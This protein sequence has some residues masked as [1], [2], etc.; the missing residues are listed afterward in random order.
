MLPFGFSSAPYVFTSIFKPLQKSWRSQGIPIAIFLDDGLGGGTDFVSAKVNSLVVHSDL[1]KSGFVPNEEKSLWEPVQVI[2]WLGVVLDTIDGTIKATDE[3]IEKL[4][5]GL[6]ELLSCQPPRKVHVKRVASVTGQII[7]LSPC[8]GSVARIMTRFLFSVVNS[9]RSWESEVFLSDDSL[10]EISFW[11]DNVVFLNSKVCW[12]VQSLPVKVTFSDASN[13]ACGAF[14]KNSNLVFHQ[15]WSPVE[16]AQSSTWRELKAV[17]LALEAFASHF[18]GVKV[19]WY[20][21][22]QNVESIL[23]NG[24]R[25]ADLHQLALLAF[26][27]CLKFH[28]SL[29][30]KWIPRELNVRA[31]AL[32]KLIDHDDYSINEAIFQRIDLFWGPH[33][34]DRFACSYNAKVPRFNTRFFQAGCAAVDAFSQDWGHD[35]NWICPP[36]CLLIRVVKHMELCK[37]RGTV[38]LPL[39]KSSCFWTVFC[40]DGVHWNSFVIDWLF[41]PKFP[42]LFIKG[43]ARNSLFGSRPLNFDVIAL[44]IDF[45][46]PRS[47]CAYVGFCTKFSKDCDRC[48]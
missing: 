20:S 8:V 3:R 19:I 7:S 11:K 10:S 29:E 24:S 25:K 17:C 38:I 15:N 1:L 45:R 34:V 22:N 42:G 31:D 6:V 30:V 9:A 36:V 47:P 48:N 39:W 13:S 44:R 46:R 23:Q 43:K 33:T 28:I 12:S 16:R 18:S 14:V 41:L 21:D 2:T 32:S 26:Q 37:A 4:N 40:R 5:A 35:N 27:I